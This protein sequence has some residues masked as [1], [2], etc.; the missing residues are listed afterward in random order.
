MKTFA[1]YLTLMLLL[2]V[3]ACAKDIVGF[4]CSISGIVKDANTGALIQNCSVTLGTTGKTT[5]TGSEGSFS[6]S[7]VDPGTY[8]LT[9]KKAGYTDATKSVTVV[10]GQSVTADILLTAKSAFALSDTNLDFGDLNSSLSFYLF[11][12]SDEK[13]SYEIKNIP[14]WASFSKTSGTIDSN[15]GQ[16]SITVMVNRDAVDYGKYSQTVCVSYNGKT[17]GDASLILKM[18][19]V[20]LSEPSVSI[21]DAAEIVTQNSFTIRGT[22]TATG[23]SQ[24]TSYGHC[25]SLSKNPTVNDS[26]TDLGSTTELGEFTSSISALTVGT[27]YYVR[28][29][30]TNNIGTSYS[31]EI[32]VTTQD[33]TSNKWDGNIATSFAGGS[34]TAGNPYQIET[35]GQLLLMKDYA[36]KYFVLKNNIDLNNNNWKPFKFKG[37]LDGNGCTIL[38]LKIERSEDYLGLFSELSGKVENFTVKG[39][40]INAESANNV[41]TIAGY[42]NTGNYGTSDIVSNVKVVFTENSTILGK[43][44]VGGISGSTRGSAMN[45]GEELT[46]IRDC[47]VS[48]VNNKNSIKGND[49]VGGIVG[50]ADVTT[51][52]AFAVIEHCIVSVPIKAGNNV[53]GIIGWA[54]D[55]EAFNCGY[56]GTISGND[57]VGGIVGFAGNDTKIIACKADATI[58]GN[59]YVA[60]IFGGADFSYAIA[61]YSTGSI[62]GSSIIAGI[63]GNYRGSSCY[64]CYSTMTSTSSGYSSITS[65]YMEDCATTNSSGANKTE[66]TDITTYMKECYSKYASY[67]NFN[68]T[69]IWK[70]EV[71]GVEKSVSCPRLAWE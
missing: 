56:S 71:N 31:Q 47:E 52:G 1:K 33:V 42:I 9:F 22:L 44:N 39:V 64:H 4:T 16:E 67:W 65:G 3:S 57:R 13:C 38:N 26:K 27:T 69:W 14:S 6:F 10:A 58:N 24:I 68:N 54:V 7:D 41:G 34:G 21:A 40:Q 37:S 70:G 51:S 28:A 2:I 49:N 66:C 8:T 12:N 23:G 18:E 61:C 15:G 59:R 20:R 45:Y 35:G 19:K 50:R 36:D 46:V 5:I 53:G 17:K 62:S 55:G 43:D 32:A 60:G 48:S 25:W 11:N 30:A 29:Y 63:M